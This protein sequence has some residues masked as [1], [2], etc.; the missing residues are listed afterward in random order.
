MGIS[1]ALAGA[2]LLA[3][4][5][6]RHPGDIHGALDAWEAQLR[7]HMFTP[8]DQRRSPCGPSWH[9]ASVSR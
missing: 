2:D 7:P 3:T 8:G 5:L 6:E 9:A 4:M 1:T